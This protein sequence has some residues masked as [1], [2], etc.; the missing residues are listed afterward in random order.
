M[1]DDLRL[2]WACYLVEIRLN[3]ASYESLIRHRI[4][5]QTYYNLSIARESRSSTSTNYSPHSKYAS[6]IW[7]LKECWKTHLIS[8]SIVLSLVSFDRILAGRY[9]H[10]LCSFNFLR[11]A[12]RSL[13]LSNPRCWCNCPDYFGDRWDCL[14]YLPSFEALL[15]FLGFANSWRNLAYTY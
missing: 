10:C 14:A 5:S 1:S 15:S 12:H 9:F 2:E 4:H 11:F 7:N 8:Y 6:S 3:R 13:R